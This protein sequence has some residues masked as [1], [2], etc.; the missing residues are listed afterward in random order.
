L[1]LK[2]RKWQEERLALLPPVQ[3]QEERVWAFL[4][5]C[6]NRVMCMGTCC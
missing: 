1:V 4:E 3:V 5:D 6:L 2:E